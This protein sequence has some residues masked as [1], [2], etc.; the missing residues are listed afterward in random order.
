VAPPAPVGDGRVAVV[1]P[2]RGDAGPLAGLLARLGN[3]PDEILVVSTGD[4]DA[5]RRV[6][7]DAGVR[8]LEARAGRGPQQHAGALAAGAEWLWFLHADALPEPGASARIR[9]AGSGGAVGGY[10]RF[11]F[12]GSVTPGRRLLA[13]L[14]N[15]RTRLGTPYGDQGLFFRRDIY[16]E[17]GGFP[18]EPLFEEV[19][20]VRRARRRGDF[21][22]LPVSLGVS[23]RRWE[24]D[25]WLSRTLG[26]R[27]LALGYAM[28]ISPRR[29][30][31]IYD[32][33][34]ENRVNRQTR[35]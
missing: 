31:R 19:P 6:C 33:Q 11:R 35:S 14:I 16:L 21:A 15:L 18:D 3:E 28:G 24:R 29:L 32:N 30:A 2:V 22:A 17:C 25:G 4:D 20:L 34:E 5:V 9:E 26:N 23:P 7:A 10:F 13:A 8:C 1:I 27:L 12:R